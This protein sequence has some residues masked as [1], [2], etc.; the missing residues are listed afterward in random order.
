MLCSGSHIEV[1][2]IKENPDREY[3]SDTEYLIVLM[4]HPCSQVSRRPEGLGRR[5]KDRKGEFQS[6]DSS[7]V[8]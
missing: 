5:G 7:L 8:K 6:I 3:K 2:E 4:V 1:E